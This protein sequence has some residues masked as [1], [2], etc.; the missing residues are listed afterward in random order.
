MSL[1]GGD[2]VVSTQMEEAPTFAPC[3]PVP[4][5]QET[6]RKNPL[7]VPERYVRSEE[8]IEKVLYMPHFSS[9]VP[10][11]DFGLL[12]HGNKNELLK[13][14]IACKEW[15]FFQIVN[16]G[17][18]IDL[19]QRLKDVVAEFF[20]LSIEE[21]DKY[22]MPP[23]DIQGYGHTSVVSE[24][25][26]LDWC[27]QLILLVYPTR[28]RKPQFWPETPEKLKDT[29]EAYSSEIKRVGEELINS[30]SLIFG[31]EEHVLLGLHKEVLQGLRVNYYPPCNTPEQVIG[32]TPHSD[33]S[34]VTIVMQD[35]D[36]T[37]L[38]VRYK[39]NW[40]PINPIPNAL[41]V[42][43]GDVIE[44]LSN[45]KYKSV[46]HRAMTNKNK[47]RTSFVSFLFPRDD[48]ELGPF[49]HMIDDQNPKMYKEIT[50]GEYLRHT[51]N[52][53]LEGKTQT[54]ATKIKEC[55]I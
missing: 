1:N 47:R 37:G 38:E 42:N 21:K 49:D 3:L 39:G 13:L 34:T 41:V 28:F 36:V 11:I 18:E 8:E 33:A 50:Y 43:L 46:E 48:A 44:V 40:V 32:L 27:D 4:N 55:G 10:V 30:L 53:K 9:Q 45:G 7:K 17:M 15:G 24:K 6:V 26:I 12:S 35:D 29:I 31:L 25:Q 54:D 20:D 5:I 23:D 19:M 52:R 22:A 2:V 16:H 14:D 51:L